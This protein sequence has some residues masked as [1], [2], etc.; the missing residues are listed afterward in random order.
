MSEN[1]P[2]KPWSIDCD[3]PGGNIVVERQEGDKAWVHHDLRG[4]S[5]WWF[6]WYF[7][8]KN[9]GGKTLQ[10]IFTK[11]FLMHNQ[12]VCVS[13]DGGQTWAWSGAQALNPDGVP[14]F[15]Y[16]V[17]GGASEIRFAISFPY[18]QEHLQRLLAELPAVTVGELCRSRHGRSVELLRLGNPQA[19]RKLY[20]TA[21]HHACESNGNWVMEGALREICADSDVGEWFRQNVDVLAVP[22]V[23]KDGVEEGDQGK[24]RTPHDHNRDYDD[25]R[26]IY[27]EVAAIKKLVPEWSAGS[28]II[29]TDF[30]C[31]YINGRHAYMVPVGEEQ[32]LVNMRRFVQIV[33][34]LHPGPGAFREDDHGG[35]TK[36]NV[37]K[38]G[39]Q[40]TR[41][42]S[43][44]P[45]MLMCGT[46]ET[47]YCQI[48]DAAV[49]PAN[50]IVLGRSF[51]KAYQALWLELT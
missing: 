4:T 19:K 49:T 42:L 13:V 12:G 9:A 51:A 44:L 11:K 29:A 6:Y 7:R 17:P 48:H 45:G 21:R 24:D 41:W 37:Y 30:H 39:I 18:L 34:D 33:A 31:P 10:F 40:S 22:F 38:N 46:L 26:V 28:S 20:L 25:D 23:D 27:P 35:L 15:R 43:T 2:T 3:F 16:I 36:G 8:V 47:P 32:N 5:P 50:L 1:S 14:G